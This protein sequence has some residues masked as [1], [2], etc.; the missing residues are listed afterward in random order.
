MN[1]TFYYI[2]AAGCSVCYAFATILEQIAAKKQK[3][4]K[5]LNPKNLIGLFNQLPY[6]AGIVL[7]LAGG[8]LFLLASRALPLFLVFSFVAFSL[9]ITAVINKVILGNSSS[10]LEKLAIVSVVIGI[11][12]LAVVA[13][14]TKVR[15]V[16]Q[17]FVTILE[18]STIPIGLIGFSMLKANLNRY[19]GLGLGALAGLSFGATG[20]ISRVV[21]FSS[22]KY[23]SMANTGLSC[24]WS[25]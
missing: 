3:D 10:N 7:D 24:L 19:S 16:N 6:V 14:P 2:S 17:A 9:V 23:I 18:L 20:L 21:H 5:S 15:H 25:P 8:G 4:I 13:E 12:L 11:I 22:L 1:D